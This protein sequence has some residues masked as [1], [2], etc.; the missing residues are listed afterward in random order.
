MDNLTFNSSPSLLAILS[1]Q[2]DGLCPCVSWLI[3]NS[4]NGFWCSMNPALLA[5]LQKLMLRSI[6]VSR[7]LRRYWARAPN[8]AKA[9]TKTLNDAAATLAH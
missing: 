3:Q 5:L 9:V 2:S 4:T 6:R 7:E 8:A 1:K